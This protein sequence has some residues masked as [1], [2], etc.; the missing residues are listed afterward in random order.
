MAKS[1]RDVLRHRRHER[2]RRKVV[3]TSE[4]PRL[5]VYKSLRH[6]YAQVVDDTRG[7]TLTYASTLEADLRK[8]ASGANRKAAESLGKLIA[9]RTQAKG[10]TAV[11]FDRGGYPYHGVV[12]ALAEAAREQGLE[13]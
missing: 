7:V 3:G 10:V 9:E 11:V 13:F 5:C 4:R 12:Q 2:I 8:G 6:L 1:S